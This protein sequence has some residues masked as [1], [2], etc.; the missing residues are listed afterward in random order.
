MM[1]LPAAL[2]FQRASSLRSWLHG[3]PVWPTVRWQDQRSKVLGHGC[4]VE[5]PVPS[6]F[7]CVLSIRCSHGDRLVRTTSPSQERIGYRT[8]GR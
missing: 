5:G 7:G 4:A 2:S 8:R 1:L 6:L 3:E